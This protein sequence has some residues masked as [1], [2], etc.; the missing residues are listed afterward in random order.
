MN[1]NMNLSDM[2]MFFIFREIIYHD[3]DFVAIN[4]NLEDDII[5][6]GLESKIERHDGDCVPAIFALLKEDDDEHTCS[7]CIDDIEK[8]VMYYQLDCGHVFH[9]NCLSECCHYSQE[10]PN[11]RKRYRVIKTE[12]NYVVE[13]MF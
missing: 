4:R 9:M 12:P 13:N 1:P 6:E 3:V 5:E 11:C 2:D 7:I 8:G 10:C